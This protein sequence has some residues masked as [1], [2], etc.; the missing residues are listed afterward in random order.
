MNAR[1]GFTLIE[2][3]VTIAIAGILLALAIPSFREITLNNQRASRVNEFVTALNYARGQALALRMDVVMCRIASDADADDPTCGG[4]SGWEEGWVIRR[5]STTGEVLRIQGALL[6]TTQ[7][8]AD[9]DARLTIRGNNPVASTITF[10]PNGTGTAGALVL[11]DSR[12]DFAE[13]RGIIISFTGR[14]RTVKTNEPDF[15]ITDCNRA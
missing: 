15:S 10:S 12:N 3:V 6:P 4:G 1:P 8:S 2:L 7:L 14:V 13:G 9:A 5:G 11:C